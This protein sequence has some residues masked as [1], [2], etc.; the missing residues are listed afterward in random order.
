MQESIMQ[1]SETATHIQ[2][3]LIVYLTRNGQTAKIAK[4]IQQQLQEKGQVVELRLLNEVTEAELQ[5]A[6]QI[7]IASAIRYGHFH[8]Q[9]YAFIE[10]NVALLNSKKST[11]IS[12]NLTARKADKNTPETNAYTRKFLEKITWKPD[13]ITVVAG[14][15]RYPKYNFF[16]RV[17]IQL[18]M[19]MTGGETDPSKEV[20]YTDW[21]RLAEF[22]QVL[23]QDIVKL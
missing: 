5:S 2:Q 1:E 18:I 19:R 21:Q 4:F 16:D 13:H 9:L 17:M 11:F 12:I 10:R 3:S 8:K 15:L 14:A 6:E 7:I 22:C 23:K 20:E